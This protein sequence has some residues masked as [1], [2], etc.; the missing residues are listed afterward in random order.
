VFVDYYFY[1]VVGTM[2]V[3]MVMVDCVGWLLVAKS[4]IV[5]FIHNST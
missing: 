3:Y 5:A 2:A 4:Y 1:A